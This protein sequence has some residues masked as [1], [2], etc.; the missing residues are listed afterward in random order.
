MVNTFSRKYRSLR[1]RPSATICSRSRVGG[2]DHPHVGLDRLVAADPLEP[3]LLEHPQDLR[4][5]QRRHVADLVEEEG[6]AVALLELADPLAVG[7]GERA[8]LVAEQLAL[9]QGLRDGRAV[10]RQER[11]V[12]PLGSAGRWPGPPAPCRCRSRRGSAR[13]R[14]AAA[15][16]PIALYTSCM[17]GQRPTSS[18]GRRPA[19][20]STSGDR[21]RHAHQ[22]AGL[23]TPG[24]SARAG[25][26]R[27][28]GLSRYSNAP[29]FIASM[30]RSVVPWPVMRM[31]GT[32][33]VD[34]ADAVER[35]QPGRRRAGG[36]RG[37]PRPAGRARPRRAPRRAVAAVQERHVRRRGTPGGRRAGWPAR[38]R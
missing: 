14:P 32:A 12:G 26:R 33:G 2:R 17:A 7:P 8:L 13:S 1:N 22:P 36:R 34:R 16:R 4:L 37:R 3:L 28:S 19:A 27:S 5:G 23:A 21:G 31:T 35:V 20:G 9:Q 30:A 10:D 24:R 29:C 15:T 38:R 18:V 25:G 11:L 6:A